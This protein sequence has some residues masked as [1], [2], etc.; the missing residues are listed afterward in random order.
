LG[1][2][3]A[4]NNS[5][6]CA[7]NVLFL[8]ATG[9][10][11]GSY[12]WQGPGGFSST[13]P[14][15]SIANV[16]T[17]NS[18]VYTVTLQSAFCGS[19]TATTNV[20]VNPSIETVQ[21]TNNGPVCGGATVNLVATNIEG[22][23]YSWRGPNGFTATGSS[24]TISNIS[25]SQA[26]P[27]NVS[28]LLAGCGLITRTTNVTVFPP[29]INFSASNNGP[30]CLG[31]ELQ[32]R[33]SFYPGAT[34]VWRGPNGFS[35]T[36]QNPVISNLVEASAGV[37]TVTVTSAFCGSASATTT[38]AVRGGVP[39]IAA[40]NN[41][42]ICN[43]ETLN[44]GVTP[45]EGAIYQWN[46]PSGFSST[47]SSLSIANASSIYNGVYSVTVR[48]PACP[49]SGRTVT[50]TVNVLPGSPI[51]SISDPSPA[52][53]C[54]GNAVNFQIQF[55]GEPPFVLTYAEGNDAPI[56]VAVPSSSYTLSL[57]PSGTGPRTYSFGCESILKTV[58]VTQ[59]LELSLVSQ[60]PADCNTGLGS[61]SVA[62]IRGA[63]PYVYTLNP[64]VAPPNTT[65]RFER[66]GAGVYEIT[67]SDRNGCLAS[68]SFT[69]EGISSPAPVVEAVTSNSAFLR[70]LALPEAQS[71][72]VEYRIAGAGASF[73]RANPTTQTSLAIEGLRPSTLYEFRIIAVCASGVQGLPSAI[74]SAQT[75]VENALG[76][77]QT[78]ELYAP[79]VNTNG[80]VRFSWRPN[81]SGAVCYIISYGRL[82]E[83]PENWIQFLAPHPNSSIFVTGIPVGAEY[84]VRIRTNCSICSYNSGQI[85]NWSPIT[86]FRVGARLE[87]SSISN[88]F[89]HLKIYPN[90]NR[91]VFSVKLQSSARRAAQ[92]SVLD[93][94]GKIIFSQSREA[95]IG[96]ND[97]PLQLENIS[98][99]VYIL[100][101]AI[102][103]E[104]QR[105]RIVIE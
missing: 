80:N 100:E 25:E 98:S 21:A 71:Y 105:A 66:I 16:T 14:N 53:V 34:Y 9:S 15:P 26:G 96:E 43:G 83:N 33:A 62:A 6:L 72:I 84:G 17:A 81:L 63:A 99:G 46:G 40:T 8:T 57:T 32:L 28:I 85:T 49:G 76:V 19:S 37:Y 41:S 31:E 65:G 77:C 39:P 92:I 3:T 97:W 24:V 45:V 104:T 70:W 44:L 59:G 75:D 103:G 73:I 22:A 7:G 2:I 60:I 58:E 36:A 30:G 69:L 101:V 51:V 61:L 79:Q 29:I 1:N 82:N 47:L 5:P 42:P 11:E 89:S 52:R 12:L 35:S 48:Y 55:E 67:V 87:E 38:F 68:N 54:Q 93:L 102:G 50:T 88:S 10:A 90:P 56:S 94:A 95:E 13:S 4:G 23:A 18:G 78:P 86:R 27:Y 20:I 64:P 74:T 91:G